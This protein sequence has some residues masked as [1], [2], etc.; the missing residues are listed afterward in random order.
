MLVLIME[1]TLEYE[2]GKIINKDSIDEL[3]EL[4]EHKIYIPIEIKQINEKEKIK[5]M[6]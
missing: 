6:E 3:K 2:E 1:A 5:K 4:L